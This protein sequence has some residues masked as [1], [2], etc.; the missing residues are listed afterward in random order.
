MGANVDS[1]WQFFECIE[2]FG[3]GFPLPVDPFSEGSAGNILHP[4]HQLDQPFV[5]VA[6]GRG[7]TDAAI[8][9]DHRGDAMP[10]GGSHFLVPRRLAIV[11]GVNV[12]ETGGNDLAS[13]IDHLFR[14]AFDLADLGYETV[15]HRDIAREAFCPRSVDDCAAANNQVEVSHHSLSHFDL[16][17]T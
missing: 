2:I 16:Q 11:M 7:E 15:L 10:R 12:Y 13:G 5:L 17:L 4:F 9:H 1:A 3:K 8:A 14:A 6:A